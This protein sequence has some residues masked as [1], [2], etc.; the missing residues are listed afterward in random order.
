MRFDQAALLS[1]RGLLRQ[2][3]AGSLALALPACSA[4]APAPRAVRWGRDVCEFCHMV[5]ADRRHAAQVWNATLERPQIYDDFGCSVLAA[6]ERGV[7]EDVAVAYW[8]LDENAPTIWLDARAARYRDGQ[9][10]PMGYGHSAGTSPGH[11]LDFATAARAI[12]EKAA[13]E[14][15]S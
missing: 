4:V 14:H 12:V 3:G 13:C 11:S 5:F 15:R 8:V 6:A 2:A 10:T 1:R 7:L 9:V